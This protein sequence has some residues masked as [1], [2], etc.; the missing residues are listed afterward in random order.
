MKSEGFDVTV[1]TNS[2]SSY[3]LHSAFIAA[4]R[5]CLCGCKCKLITVVLRAAS[6]IFQIS[7]SNIILS[8]A[9]LHPALLDHSLFLFPPH[10]CVVYIHLK[11]PDMSEYCPAFILT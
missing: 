2:S 11:A 7:N 4:L 8:P 5:T 3:F 10:W 9:V 6:P 1:D